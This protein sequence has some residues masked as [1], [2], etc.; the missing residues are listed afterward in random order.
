MEMVDLFNQRRVAATLLK[1]GINRV[2]IDPNRTEDVAY[3]VTRDDVRNLIKSG[4]IRAR[5]KR[6]SSRGRIRV[7]KD[8]RRKGKRKGQGSRKGA[9]YA[10]FPK[11][12]RWIS[13]IRPIRGQLRDLRDKNMIERNVYRKFYLYAKGGMFKNKG[14][15]M[16]HLKAENL[17]KEPS[18]EKTKN[19]KK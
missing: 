13:T 17:L 9:K 7:A 5:Q 1:C 18:K 2:W 12:Q 8:Q 4:F 11:K 16:A 19:K 14:H 10:R 3:A 6:G 15:I